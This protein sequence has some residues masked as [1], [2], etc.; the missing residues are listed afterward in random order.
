MTPAESRVATHVPQIRDG[1]T[2]EDAMHMIADHIEELQATLDGYSGLVRYLQ[3][4]NTVGETGR[5]FGDIALERLQ[6]YEEDWLEDPT[7]W[8]HV[9]GSMTS[10]GCDCG[11]RAE[12]D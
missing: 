1:M 8:C 12:N 10:A 6:R 5:H 7:P 2:M 3:G 9:C 11:P 4:S